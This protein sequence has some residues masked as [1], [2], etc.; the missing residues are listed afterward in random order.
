MRAPRTAIAHRAV[1]QPGLIGAARQQRGVG[2]LVA[3]LAQRLGGVTAHLGIGVGQGGQEGGLGVGVGGMDE[4]RGQC[5]ADEHR[6]VGCFER[7]RQARGC[8]GVV[9]AADRC[10]R[11]PADIGVGV[12][13]ERQERRHGC[14][15]AAGIE[16][17]GGGH[18]HGRVGVIRALAQHLAGRLAAQSAQRLGRGRP[19]QRV[20]IG[21]GRGEQGEDMA[22]FLL[23]QRRCG[24]PTDERFRVGQ[25]R[26]QTGERLGA[27]L[28]VAPQG[29]GRFPADTRCAGAQGCQGRG[30][31]RRLR[32]GVAGS[33]AVRPPL[34]QLRPMRN[35]LS[36]STESL[37]DRMPLCLGKE[38]FACT[39]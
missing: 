7:G 21:Q 31:A 16:G 37:H 11:S 9:V 39:W 34:R 26:H 17:L 19:A 36:D 4:G 28:R 25:G 20:R 27:E 6:L 38:A 24:L 5:P 14:D 8:V 33:P 23:R 22:G 2:L 29:G 30:L 13:Q 1:Q 3:D 18:P 10:G 15:V 35:C 32:A 12:G